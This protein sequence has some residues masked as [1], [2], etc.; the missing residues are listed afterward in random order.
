MEDRAQERCEYCHA[1]QSVCGYRFHLERIVPLALGGSDAEDNRALACAS[2]NLTKSDHVSGSDPLR[3]DTAPLFHPRPH[4]WHEHFAWD[5]D[6]RTLTA[7]T[8]I[9]RVTIA[10]LS[11]NSDLHLIARQ[12][13]FD[14]GWLP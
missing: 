5:E 13:W 12:L 7:L 11:M 14:S 4:I 2:C 6:Q 1:P 10:T 8:S 9:G 3:G